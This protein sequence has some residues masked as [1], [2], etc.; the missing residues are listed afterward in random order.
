M[1]TATVNRILDEQGRELSALAESEAIR[2]FI[3]AETRSTLALPPSSVTATAHVQPPN[4]PIQLEAILGSTLN[5][6]SHFERVICFDGNK[7][8][9]FLAERNQGRREVGALTIHRKDFLPGLPQPM[10]RRGQRGE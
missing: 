8:P 7:R 10:R 1:F 5:N 2:Q 4:L 9:L 6:Y 3:A